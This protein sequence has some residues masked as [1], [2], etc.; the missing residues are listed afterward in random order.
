MVGQDSHPTW[1]SFRGAGQ[2]DGVTNADTIK[3]APVIGSLQALPS[4]VTFAGTETGDCVLTGLTLQGGYYGIDG[5]R[6]LANIRGNNISDNGI[7]YSYGYYDG[8]NWEGGGVYHCEGVIEDNVI[9]DNAARGLAYCDGI[10]RSNDITNNGGWADAYC[11][12]HSGGGLF[13]CN[14]LIE[15]NVIVGN[16]GV[17]VGGG[18]ANCNGT[19]RGNVIA[20]NEAQGAGGGPSYDPVS[21][22]GGLWGCNGLIEGNLIMSNSASFGGG[23]DYCNGSIVNNTIVGNIA[24]GAG[25]GDDITPGGE[26]VDSCEGRFINNLIVGTILYSETST[27]AY[28]NIL[29]SG[30]SGEDWDGSIGID[31]GGNIDADPM[32]VNADDPAGSDGKWFTEDDGLRLLSGSPCIDAANGDVAPVVDIIGQ[33]RFDYLARANTGT[34]SPNYADIGAYEF[35]GFPIPNEVVV[36][37]RDGGFSTTGS[38]SESG[39]I[40]EYLGS[41]LYSGQIGGTARWTPTLPSA[42]LW[43]VYAWW[44]NRRSDGTLFDRDSAA[45]YVI[46]DSNGQSIVTVDQDVNGGKWNLLGT[47]EFNEGANGYIELVRDENNT[48]FTSADAVW[49]VKVPAT[50]AAAT[51]ATGLSPDLNEDV[52]DW[53]L[54][55]ESEPWMLDAIELHA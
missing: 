1:T 40:D 46:H 53:H 16:R 23:I 22:G 27:F 5:N 45:D 21:S 52:S 26:G 49:L 24:W 19:V 54:A 6:T 48:A 29:N 37:N 51:Q 50:Y 2:S 25:R 13:A 11:S 12:S 18:L 42:G 3:F 44:S 9:A 8:P 14:G 41:S 35:P 47:F 34:G 20:S 28:C 38:W 43:Q 32:F 17:G 31:G 4:V 10:I 30:G 15:G 33:A 36:D 55:Q 7:A 39:S